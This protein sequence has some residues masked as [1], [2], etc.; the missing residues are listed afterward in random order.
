MASLPE[1]RLEN[2]T[3]ACTETTIGHFSAWKAG[4][5]RWFQS[6]KYITISSQ[7]IRYALSC[8][9]IYGHLRLSL[10]SHSGCKRGEIVIKNMLTNGS[11]PEH[12]YFYF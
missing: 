5:Y 7:L 3:Q 8:S 2:Q 6:P 12:F 4:K 10:C 1:W 11:Y 9:Q